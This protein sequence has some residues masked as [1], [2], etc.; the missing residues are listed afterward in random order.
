MPTYD[1]ECGSCDHKL[2]IFQ[3]INDPVKKKC[4]EC[5]KNKLKRLFG[6]G[7]AI[8]FKGSGFYQTD[9]RSEGYKKA[10]KADKK[11]SSD[12]AGESKSSENKSKPKA[13]AKPKPKSTGKDA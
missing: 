13:E 5:G 8:V 11:T 9:Y 1:Y 7:A 3:G 12:S 2:E 10:A 4:P 6:S